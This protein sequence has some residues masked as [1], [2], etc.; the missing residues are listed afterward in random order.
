MRR[1]SVFTLSVTLCFILLT[2]FHL[3]AGTQDTNLSKNPSE[4]K[5]YYGGELG[6][7]FGDY[8]QISIVPMI[9]YKVTPKFH[10]GGKIGYS[11]VNDKRYDTAITSHNYG[12]SIFSRYLFLPQL[13]A[14]AEF[15]YY[16]YKYQ[17]ER[18][19]T[20]RKWV[21]FTLVGFG[22]IQAVGQNSSLFVE[23]LW[24][25]LQDE[26]SPFSSSDA[27]VKIGFGFGL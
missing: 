20:E 1:L 24:D 6:L 23:V 3:N 12:A 18:I 14:H 15:A 25:V 4:S 19:E 22:Y 2:N 17:T 13:Y 16:S 5:T 27:R 8:F 11:Y 21:P 10:I 9:G 7:S 26:N